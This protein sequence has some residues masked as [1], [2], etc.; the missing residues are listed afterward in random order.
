MSYIKNLVRLFAI[1]KILV[2]YRLDELIDKTYILKPFKYLFIFFP[3]KLDKKSLL[4][5]RLRKALEEL[6]PI[7]GQLCEW[8]GRLR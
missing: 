8:G 5:K 7:L 2:S 1:Q 4:G 6:G 3:K